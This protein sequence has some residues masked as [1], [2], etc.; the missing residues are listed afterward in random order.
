MTR[1]TGLCA[2][3]LGLALCALGAAGARAEETPPPMTSA[4]LSW[5]PAQQEWG[6]RHMEK[7]APTALM[8]KKPC[9]HLPRSTT[10]SLNTKRFCT[11]RT[12]PGLTDSSSPVQSDYFCCFV[13]FCL[14]VC[15]FVFAGSPRQRRTHP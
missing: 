6:Y 15:L 5:T 4:I 13:L 7:V 14:F 11:M 1:R 8:L 9:G 3:G 10:R 12:K 2:L